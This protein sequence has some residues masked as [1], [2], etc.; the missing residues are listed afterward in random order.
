MTTIKA[1]AAYD[2]ETPLRPYSFDRKELGA[3][4]V[5]IE[6]L[7]SGVCHS[8]IHTA[9]GDWGP[10]I[11]PLVPGHEIVGR[12]TAVGSEVTKFKIGE[13]AGVGCFVDSCRTC[14]SCKSGEE[15]FCE[16]GM[17][18]TYNSY[19]RGTKIPTYGGYSTSI[20]VD[21]DYTLHISDKLELSAVAPLLCAGIT[22]YS[23]LRYLKVGKGH[24]V[25]VLG[26][27]GLGHMA[28]KFAVSFGAEVTMLSHSPSKE[29]DAKKLGA[30]HFALTSDAATMDSLANKF[31][32]ILNTVSAKHD[33]NAYLNLL[34]TNGTMI[35]V[36]VPTA[37]AEIPAITL[38]LK[39]R[40]IMGSLIG[41]IAE[42]QEMLDYCAEH[43][44]TS[45]VE[46]IDMSYINEA[47]E[48]MNK[49]DVKYRFVIDMASLK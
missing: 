12:I 25:G 39:R 29:A 11:Y 44:I 9:K 14:P 26:L 3:K 1:Y 24:K 45:D 16:E 4:Q 10:A 2:A 13:L 46:V 18:G 49:S 40:K 5:Q 22:T 48:R 34:N 47:Y 19:E 8:D 28:V 37:P 36:G 42:T 33:Y 20:T 38:I 21:E 41:G 43:N 32:F 6:I 31:D 30:H 7:Y 15:Q 17:T 35:I 23:P 27:G